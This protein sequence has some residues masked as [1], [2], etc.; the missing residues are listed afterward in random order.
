VV[1]WAGSDLWLATPETGAQLRLADGVEDVVGGVFGKRYAVRANGRVTLFDSTWKAQG[2]FG[3]KV[4]SLLRAGKSLFYT[5]SV[6]AHRIVDGKSG[7]VLEETLLAS[8]ACSMG[9]QDG[10][11]V[12]FRSPCSGGKVLAVNEPSGQTFTLPFDADPRQLRLTPALKSRGT[13]PLKD[14]FWFFFLRNGDSDATRN[15]L[16]VRTPA[17]AERALGAHSTLLQLRLL[18]TASE[19][20][21]YA[22]IDITGETGRY[23]W[24]NEAGETRVLADNAMWRTRR[25]V[26]DFD[27]V[28]GNVAAASGDRLEVLAKRVP[29]Q[30]FEY[31]DS[32]RAWTVIFHDT[33]GDNGQLSVFNDGIDSL[34][35]IPPDKPFTL[36][37]LAPVASN[38]PALRTS[39]LNDVLSGVIYFTDLDPV[40]RTGHLEYRNL[41]LRFTAR[42]ND[43]VSDFVVA[44]DEVLYAIPYGENAGIWLVA[45]K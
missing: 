7:A 1:V 10:T 16:F 2:T 5:D 39:S 13:D 22:L 24:W 31:Q 43:D 35:A 33:D 26:V 3:D 11:W 4:N 8:D 18:E 41:E 12:T 30:A 42:V 19:T 17:G 44:H 36:P 23:I 20:H 15:T 40:T 29:W 28:L 45:G 32:T 27:G 34:Q 6:G 38:V 14:P 21:G 9:A 37:T 25:L